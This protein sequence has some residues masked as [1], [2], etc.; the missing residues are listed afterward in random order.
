MSGQ[1]SVQR[2]AVIAGGLLAAATRRAIASPI[3]LKFATADTMND[4]SYEVG[5]R[6]GAELAKRTNGKYDVQMFVGGA[7]G[8]TVNLANSLQ[9][10]IIDCAILTSGYLESFVPSV[11][12]IDL[13]FIFKDRTTAESLLDGDLGKRLFADMAGRGIHG[14]A[15]GWYGWR[16]MEIRDRPVKTPDDMKGLKIRIQPGPVFAAMFR[17]LGAIPV[18]LDGSEVYLGLSQHTVG[19]VEFPLPTAVTFKVYEVT[20]YLA[21]TRHSYNAGALMVSNA[22]WNQLTPEEQAAFQ[23]SATAV[24]PFWR[25]TIA[26]R[27]DEALTFLKAHGMQPTDTD[28]KAFQ[29]KMK[30]VYDQFSPKYPELFH[31]I[32]EHNA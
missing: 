13:P 23:E 25:D 26:K 18:P 22:R 21:L 30:T 17:A 24:L 1:P 3:Q 10:G 6:F 12:S 2:R 7:L 9:T 29:D 31:M 15:W 32:M 27:S 28:F 14:L 16:Q 19:G 4:T 20:K 11:Q 5:Q 8:S